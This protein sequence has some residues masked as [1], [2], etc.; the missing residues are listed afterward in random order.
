[1]C[2]LQIPTSASDN[3]TG[4]RWSLHPTLFPALKF[5]AAK[6]RLTASINEKATVVVAIA[7]LANKSRTQRHTVKNIRNYLAFSG[8]GL[9]L[10]YFVQFSTEA[11]EASARAQ[12]VVTLSVGV[13]QKSET[14][15]VLR[16]R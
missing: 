2:W 3:R 8:F 15:L 6:S 9:L 5:G 16:V 11:G 12:T 1:M 14:N 7:R 13:E 4:R 10:W